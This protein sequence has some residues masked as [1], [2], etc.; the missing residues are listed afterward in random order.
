MPDQFTARYGR[1][2]LSTP[3]IAVCNIFRWVLWILRLFCT[4]MECIIVDWDPVFCFWGSH[5]YILVFGGQ[6]CRLRSLD[7]F[8]LR[9]PGLAIGIMY[10]ILMVDL[11]AKSIAIHRFLC[12]SFGSRRRIRRCCCFLKICHLRILGTMSLIVFWVWCRA[13]LWNAELREPWCYEMR[14]YLCP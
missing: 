2:L 5:E 14:Y 11:R 3:I 8:C 7:L 12:R 9:L 10:R 13:L 1:L 6:R 4:I